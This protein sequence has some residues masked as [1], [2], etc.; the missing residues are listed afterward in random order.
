[1]P[2]APTSGRGDAQVHLVDAAQPDRPPRLVQRRAP[3]LQYFLEHHFGRLIILTNACG[4]PEYGLMTCELGRCARE[5][6]A[7]TSAPAAPHAGCLSDCRVDGTL[8]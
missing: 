2:V 5:C 8:R 7:L 6:A 3:G 4:G 1:V